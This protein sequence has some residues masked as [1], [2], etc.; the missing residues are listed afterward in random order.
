MITCSFC[1]YEFDE[2]ETVKSCSSCPMNKNCG[3]IK[4][5]NCNFENPK[6]LKWLSAVGG[7][8]KMASHHPG[9]GTIGFSPKADNQKPLASVNL[10]ELKPGQ[11]GKVIKIN[12]SGHD[13]V[14]KLT[15]FGIIPGE[16]L[17]LIQKFPSYVI[18]IGNT[19][20]ALDKHI[21]SNIEVTC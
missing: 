11:Q 6:P 21:A 17:F 12:L 13:D 3:K 1:G 7:W 16:D 18:K 19:Q 20:I 9:H 8:L 4:C 10:T 14:K 5:P 15:V 2:K